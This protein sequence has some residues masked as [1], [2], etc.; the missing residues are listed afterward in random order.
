MQSFH[1]RI[2]SRE[3]RR[4]TFLFRRGNGF[5][6]GRDLFRRGVGAARLPVAPDPVSRQCRQ[7][8]SPV[9]DSGEQVADGAGYDPSFDPARQRLAVVG[10]ALTLSCGR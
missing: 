1:R 7:Q 6:G 2:W 8:Y 5:V 3:T 9:S 10:H 4:L